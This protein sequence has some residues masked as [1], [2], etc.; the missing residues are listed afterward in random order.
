M[1]ALN[2]EWVYTHRYSLDC[3]SLFAFH[4][5]RGK[6]RTLAFAFLLLFPAPLV[7]YSQ[8]IKSYWK[9]ELRQTDF[10]QKCLSQR[11]RVKEKRE[12]KRGRRRDREWLLLLECR[13]ASLWCVGCTISTM[14]LLVSI[15][16][17][18]EWQELGGLVATYGA[19]ITVTA[20]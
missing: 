19:N 10:K 12:G 18:G 1:L 7:F 16:I 17:M 5:S 11:R 15:C 8:K 13:C 2:E 6:L 3:H 9:K 4:V 20:L 14:G